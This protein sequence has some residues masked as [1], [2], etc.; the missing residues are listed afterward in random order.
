MAFSAALEKV[1]D[2]VYWANPVI[3]GGVFLVGLFAFL[4]VGV[5]S[6]SS[7]SVVCY[8]L[9][10]NLVVRFAHTNGTRVLADMNVVAKRP[11]PEAPEVFVTE[12]QVQ[13]QVPVITA[14]INALL[15]GLYSLLC[16]EATP[17]V[18]KTIGSLFVLA[19]ASRLFGSTGLLFLI[20]LAA[21][22]LPKGYQL[23]KAEVDALAAVVQ[24]K[25]EEVFAQ[26]QEARAA[27][28]VWGGRGGGAG[29][30]GAEALG[31]CR[32][33]STD[34]RPRQMVRCERGKE[35]RGPLCSHSRPCDL[36][37]RRRLSPP[38]PRPAT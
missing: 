38:S 21:F 29:G 7:I 10:L 13:A 2:V 5:Y 15:R 12:E 17:V 19:L 20:Y 28:R 4:L 27:P 22:T 26:L 35:G 8:V 37:L 11:L 32:G 3:S 18:L 6:Y 24:K 23:K 14:H 25:S 1:K 30:A 9:I 33:L 16:G 34:E 31:G 36:G